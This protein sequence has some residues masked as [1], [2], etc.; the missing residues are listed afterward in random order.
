MTG[1]LVLSCCPGAGLLDSAFRD[2]GFTVVSGPDA[3]FGGDIRREHYP[4]G[5][6]AGVIGGPPCQTYS[7]A[8]TLHGT[9]A[10]DLI[11]EFVR[12]VMECRPSFVV[13]ENVPPARK[14]ARVPD[15]WFCTILRD[16]DCG[17]MTHRRR[18]FWTW[19]FMVPAT[20]RRA[21]VPAHSVM[22]STAK[23]GR[24]DNPF[25]A[26]KGYLAGDLPIAEYAR[27]QGVPEIG[28]ALEAAGAGRAFAV[29]VLGNGVP[30]AL[31]SHVARAARAWLDGENRRAVS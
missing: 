15:E 4:S 9:K 16:W 18:A 14:A 10:L 6:F 31:G 29:K 22:A 8:S 11:P 30:Y 24:S 1:E 7:T 3:L 21:G 25:L 2:A 23:R 28:A 19:P 17:G 27:L 26:A 20:G 12:V 13:M 5:V